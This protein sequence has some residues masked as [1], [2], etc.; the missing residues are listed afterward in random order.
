LAATIG[1]VSRCCGGE[2]YGKILSFVGMG[3]MLAPLIQAH[4][5]TSRE[6]WQMTQK[7]A[8]FGKASVARCIVQEQM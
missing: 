7:L 4:S 2:S 3:D 8:R 5:T 1:T 6:S